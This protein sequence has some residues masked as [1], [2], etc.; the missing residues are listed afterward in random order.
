M[1]YTNS[2]IMI[3]HHHCLRYVHCNKH[4]IMHIQVNTYMHSMGVSRHFGKEGTLFSFF[5]NFTYI[6][7]KIDKFSNKKEVQT[8][9]N[10]PP[11]PPLKD[12]FFLKRLFT[13]YGFTVDSTIFKCKLVHVKIS[14]S[15]RFHKI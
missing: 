5:V 1:K 9:C 12:I 10:N 8:P 11:F 2:I 7:Y 13:F 6:M 3:I 4:N 14:K 15:S